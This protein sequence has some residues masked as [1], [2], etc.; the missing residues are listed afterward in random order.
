MGPQLPIYGLR[1]PTGAEREGARPQALHTT[2][3]C[4]SGTCI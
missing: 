3:P 2:T 1:V 4:P